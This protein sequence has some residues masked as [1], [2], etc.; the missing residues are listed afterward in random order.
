MKT[1]KTKKAKPSEIKHSRPPIVTLMGH[2][3]HGKTSILDAIR[4]SQITKKESGGITQHIGAYT[5]EKS[6]KRITFIDTPGH[7]AFTKM[8]ARGG[9]AADIVILVVAADDGVMPQTKEAIMH[10]KAAA[11]PIV[12]AINK[13]DL[14]GVDIMRVKKQL[15][16]NGI[17]LEGFG[18]DIVAVEVSAT[19]KTGISELLDVLNL[20]AD[21]QESAL[22]SSDSDPLEFVVI[23]SRHDPRS[24]TTVSGI[25]RNG[26]FKLR[27]ELCT[28]DVQGKV[29]AIIDSNGKRISIAN[30]GD[31]V[32]ILGF[33]ETPQSGDVITTPDNLENLS[34]K[35]SESHLDT[36]IDEP[37][38]SEDEVSGKSLK[39]L[40]LVIRADTEGTLEAILSSI[41]KIRVEDAYANIMFSG[42]GEVKESDILLASTGKAVVIAFK[43]GVPQSIIKAA[44]AQKVIIRE[45]E[46]IYKLLEEIEGALQGVIE[47]EEAKVKGKGF[48]IEK[49]VLPKSNTVVAG[50][51]VEAGKLKANSRIGVFRGEGETPLY[52]ARIKSMHIGP[53]EVQVANKGDEVGVIF[54]PETTDI[55][56]DD[57]VVA[58]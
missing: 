28:K 58:L 14:P 2:V 25:V 30:P 56:L 54:K 7:E 57:R 29:K 32:E 33:T 52:V 31:A 38:T 51:L 45:H 50:I 40:N 44:E 42:T 39:T 26:S 15:A 34:E 10:A 21:M 37:G 12:V 41:N 55:N 27:D 11:V 13:V 36:K 1:D 35:L 22:T 43:V 4:E 20:I 49:F 17:L 47:I 48:V 5:V 3:D 24:G 16:D 9:A 18:G 23:E 46:I 53:N 8:R 6:G 19:K